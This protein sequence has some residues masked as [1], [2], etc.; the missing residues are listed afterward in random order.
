MID[1]DFFKRFNDH[2]G[3]IQGDA[4]LRK[5]SNVL[6][7]GTRVRV[8]P[9]PPT[10]EAKLPPSFHRIS[11][12]V[13]RADFA[14]RYGGEEFAVLLQGADLDAA[15]LVGERLRSGVENLLMAHAGA[16]WGF[17]SISIGVASV[18]PSEQSDPESLTECA[19]GA[20]YEAKQQGR[21]R[22]SGYVPVLLSQVS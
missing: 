13:R 19:D 15:L 11:G 3:H 16:P 1:V 22:V 12:R 8:D 14:A 2:Y 18:L 5:V 10:F 21:N 6:M 17:V 4:C 7:E 9:P 20:L